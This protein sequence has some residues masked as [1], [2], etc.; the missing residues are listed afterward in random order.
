MAGLA[1]VAELRGLSE[2]ELGGSAASAE[3]SPNSC[4]LVLLAKAPSDALVLIFGA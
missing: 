4:S 1:A 2:R 3:L